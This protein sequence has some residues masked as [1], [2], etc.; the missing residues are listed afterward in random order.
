MGKR[1]QPDEIQFLIDNYQKLSTQEMAKALNRDYSTTKRK[2]KTCILN[3]QEKTLPKGFVTIPSSP[4]H[5]INCNGEVIRIK[6][7]K[8]IKSYPNKK[9]YLQVCL[10]NKKSYR[11]HRL[12]AELF[13]ENPEGKPQVNHKDGN[14]LNNSHTNLE[15]V[16]NE[17]NQKHA[18]ESGLWD[19]ISPK[20][21]QRQIG[22]GNSCAKLDEDDVL[23]IYELFK[24]GVAVGVIA[25]KYNVNH[26]NIS[27]I[28]AGKS[29]KHLY[30]HYSEGSETRS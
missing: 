24:N 13:V 8:P 19:E 27:A 29:W 22:S 1:W 7:R 3:V 25:K 26:S 5:A 20:I 23:T 2:V 30:H 18:I 15:W 4:I 14:K 17:E 11:I 21:S 28:K 6:T 10:Q 9:G 12:V 16:T